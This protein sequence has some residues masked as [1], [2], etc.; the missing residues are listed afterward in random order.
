MNVVASG[1]EIEI[2]TFKEFYQNIGSLF[3]EK[4]T[5]CCMPL[6]LHKYFIH[7]LEIMSSALLPIGYLTEEEQKACNK[8]FKRYRE[9][10]SR[11]CDSTKRNRDFLN[12]L[13][14]SSDPLITNKNH[15]PKKKLQSVPKEG[16]CFLRSFATSEEM[17][18]DR[19][20]RSDTSYKGEKGIENVSDGDKIK[21]Y[22][23][24]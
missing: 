8:N 19:E 16:L 3:M 21:L 6:I 17:K 14:T 4:Y 15:L 10:N 18:V 24:A 11:K 5:R 12:M 23:F 9:H 7:A 2:E 22:S 13:L 20:I 1:H